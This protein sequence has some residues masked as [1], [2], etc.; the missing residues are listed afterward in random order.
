MW[1]RGV[2]VFCNL[3]ERPEGQAFPCRLRGLPL[4]TGKAS[5]GMG[6]CFCHGARVLRIA[7]DGRKHSIPLY[8]YARACLKSIYLAG[9]WVPIV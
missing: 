9:T 7:G 4:P 2:V 6:W 1:A 8:C 3:L 5:R